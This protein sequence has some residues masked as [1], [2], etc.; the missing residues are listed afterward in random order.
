[1]EKTLELLPDSAKAQFGVA[2]VLLQLGQLPEAIEHLEAVLRL[3]PNYPHIQALYGLALEKAGR[4]PE[5]LEHL[6][7]AIQLSPQDRAAHFNCGNTLLQ[8]RRPVEAIRE[9]QEAVRIDPAYF[10]AY[11]SL[12]VAYAAT[13]RRADA[14]AAA[15]QAI[16]IARNQN[17]TDFTNRLQSWLTN[18]QANAP[19]QK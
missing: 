15:E 19:E 17:Q 18:Y 2:T 6:E 4:L 7:L 14:T 12:A 5:A 8:L 3:D 13:G 10:D 9:L 1:L 16:T 11:A